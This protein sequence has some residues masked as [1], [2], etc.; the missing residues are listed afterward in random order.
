MRNLQRN[1]YSIDAILLT[2]DIEYSKD[3]GKEILPGFRE[4]D[5]FGPVI[6][7]SKGGTD[8]EHFAKNF[9]PPNP[10]LAPINRNW[11]QALLES[12]KIQKKYIQEGNTDYTDKIIDAGVRF[13]NLSY[14]FSNFFKSR[15]KYAI[16]EFEVNPFIFYYDGKFIAID[17]FARF[18][19]KE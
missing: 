8:A 4:S 14:Q 11:S 10:I 15:S 1:G 13:S 17:G 12:T 16:K 9:S 2:E 19:E 18:W 5:A 7:F 6:S 3:L